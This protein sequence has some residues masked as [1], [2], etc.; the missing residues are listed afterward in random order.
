[1]K[2]TNVKDGLTSSEVE[3]NKNKYGTNDLGKKSSNSR[4]GQTQNG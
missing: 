3:S 1:M 2:Y 4:N